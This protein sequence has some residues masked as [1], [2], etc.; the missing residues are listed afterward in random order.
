MATSQRF[1]SVSGFS[2]NNLEN[3]TAAVHTNSDSQNQ[4]FSPNWATLS[5][6]DDSND[7]LEDVEVTKVAK[8]AKSNTLSN[9]F[10]DPVVGGR[11]STRS[12]SS[13]SSA[14]STGCSD[15]ALESSPTNSLSPY[16]FDHEQDDN[17]LGQVMTNFHQMS[18]RGDSMGFNLYTNPKQQQQ[19][20][21]TTTTTSN[22][23]III[24]GL[25]NPASSQQKETSILQHSQ[26]QNI[27]QQQLSLPTPQQQPPPP[28]MHQYSNQLGSRALV[29]SNQL[30]SRALVDSNQQ[31]QSNQTQL[32]AN[33]A[34]LAGLAGPQS[35]PM[36]A[37]QS[38][39]FQDNTGGLN[40]LMQ[41]DKPAIMQ[42]R[43]KFGSLGETE[44]QFH[45]PHGFCMG[46]NEE[47]IVADTFNHR[48]QI[49]DKEGQFKFSFGVPGKDEGQLFYPRKI[50]VLRDSGYYVICDR[51]SERSRMQIFSP[52]GH[53][54]R[55]IPI[56][57]IDIV[58]G[59]AISREG[60]IVA[61]DSVTPTI[62]ILHENGALVK[63]IECSEYMTEP[64]DIA[65]F[66]S[67]YYIC[68]FKGHS[69]VVMHENGNFLRRIGC[70]PVT[71]FPNGI[72]ISDA[73]DILVGDSHGNQFH[74][75]VY[76]RRGDLVSQFQCPQVK[77]SRC[78]GLKITSEGYIVTLA[79][80]N[81]HV[82]ILNT[83]YVP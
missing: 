76:D 40:N 28:L 62:F 23:S 10:F 36:W 31:Q 9:N 37:P 55:R 45:S 47:I 48:I 58:A 2:S 46:P 35:N 77:V 32:M 12:S 18:L 11:N 5:F 22:N 57:F 27:Y 70:Q 69:I 83:L 6:L 39:P 59:L 71:N 61:V 14:G 4:H 73:G 79:K 30:G 21:L 65:I 74:V 53:F 42:I 19:K 81:H 56:R 34:A 8:N 54:I 16:A 49:F 1:S 68:D 43:C 15:Q 80:N 78:C 67:E 29:D 26:T 33:L 25:N 51:G 20:Q 41:N 13:R 3:S 24:A 7:E 63:Y 75:A 64:S 50:A 82:L 72:D 44:R 17:V 60:Y 52:M 66:G 38:G